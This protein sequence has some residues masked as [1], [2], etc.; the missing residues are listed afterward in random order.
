[1]IHRDLKP[2]N[3]LLDQNGNP[4]VTD[5]GLVQHVYAL[6]CA[7]FRDSSEGETIKDFHFLQHVQ[8]LPEAV[9]TLKSFP[10][11]CAHMIGGGEELEFLRA[12]PW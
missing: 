5:F 8:R 7:A 2:G 4:R 10:M 6:G 11:K 12:E 9:T 3:I 1:V